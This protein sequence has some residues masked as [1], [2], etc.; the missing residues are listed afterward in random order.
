[1]TASFF[2]GTI[3]LQPL[4]QSSVAIQLQPKQ[5]EQLQPHCFHFP[6][7]PNLLKSVVHNFVF[8][9]FSMLSPCK[10]DFHVGKKGDGA[11]TNLKAC[12]VLEVEQLIL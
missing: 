7:L 4:L 11:N 8:T 9:P 1:M 5:Q 3:S 2:F 12:Q 6:Y 10:V